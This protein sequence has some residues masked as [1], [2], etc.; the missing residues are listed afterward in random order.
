MPQTFICLHCGKTL[1]KNPRLKKIQKYCSAKKCQQARRSARKK[2]RYNSDLIYRKKHLEAQ[3]AWRENRPAHQ[4]QQEYRKNHPRYVTRNRELQK[5]RNKNRQAE[6]ATMIVNGTSLFT[7]PGNSEA[8]AV[9]KIQNKKIVNGTSF[10]ARMQIL[11]G[12][13]SILIPSVV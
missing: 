10:I 7:Q 2:V 9:L 12:K 6:S 1:P 3:K 13:E 4:Y 8:F 11:S 5:T